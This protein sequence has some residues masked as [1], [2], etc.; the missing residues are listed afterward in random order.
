MD[1]LADY[2]NQVVKMLATKLTRSE[3][4]PR[5]KLDRIFHFVRDEIRFGFPVNGDF[6]KASETIRLGYGQC[7]TK[8]TLLLALCKAAEIPSRIHFS[9][10]TKDIQKGFFRG[11]AYWLMPKEISHSWIE[12]EIEGQWRR[13]DTFINDKTLFDAAKAKIKQLGWTV[14]YSVALE[15]GEAGADLNLDHEV[16]Q[17]MAA[18]TDDHGT[19]DDPSFYYDSENYRNRPDGFRMWVYRHLIGGIN[20]RVEAVRRGV[21]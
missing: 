6:V 4:T 13:V 7:N 8:A 16:Y 19:W 11:L 1:K 2:D 3:T 15:D 5:G 18:V 10:I 12:V 17:Q 21:G 14:G 9:L 20:R